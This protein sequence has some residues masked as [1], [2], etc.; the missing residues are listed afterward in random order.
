LSLKG[1]SPAA[2]NRVWNTEKHPTWRG[3]LGTARCG[4]E[5][6]KG[7]SLVPLFRGSQD[8]WL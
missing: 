8:G 3:L 6:L 2:A 4:P 1:I 5:E 7:P